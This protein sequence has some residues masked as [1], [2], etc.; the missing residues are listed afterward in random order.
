MLHLIAGTFI[1][2]S[3][4][5]GFYVSEYFYLFTLFVGANLIQSA[6]SR[7][8]PMITVLRRMGFKEC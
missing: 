8:C 2:I 3:I 5:L 6:F 7:W 4:L 1:L